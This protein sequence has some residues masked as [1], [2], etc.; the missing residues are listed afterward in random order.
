MLFPNSFNLETDEG[1]K[2]F[3]KKKKKKRSQPS[4]VW[5]KKAH[6]KM[7]NLVFFVIRPKT[8]KIPFIKIRLSVFQEKNVKLNGNC[9][10]I[11]VRPFPS[12]EAIRNNMPRRAGT[13]ERKINS[14][15]FPS[16]SIRRR[17]LNESIF[18]AWGAS[19]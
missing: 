19:I 11:K 7:E 8:N 16:I 15:Y 1:N 4:K 6:K 13:K 18:I 17:K 5:D 9:G 2:T 10:R 3:I 14:F 12:R